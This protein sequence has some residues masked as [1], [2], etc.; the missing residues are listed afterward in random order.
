MRNGLYRIEV[1]A[2]QGTPDQDSFGVLL[3]ENAIS[4]VKLHPIKIKGHSTNNPGLPIG[5]HVISD[6]DPTAYMVGRWEACA[7][8]N[9]WKR[10]E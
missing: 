9:W 3:T 7:G 4:H 6:K 10:V 1:V 2:M 5:S 8:P